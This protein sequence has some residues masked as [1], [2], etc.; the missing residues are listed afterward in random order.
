M[1]GTRSNRDQVR[2]SRRA[3]LTPVS[4]T[5]SRL[6]LAGHLVPATE[7]L[8]R[9]EALGRL[10]DQGREVALLVLHQAC[11][12]EVEAGEVAAE[13]EQRNGSGRDQDGEWPVETEQQED[14]G[15]VSADVDDQEDQPERHEPSDGA[16]VAGGSGQQLP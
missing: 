3:L 14:D 8:D 16:Q 9:P 1:L 10:L 6:E 7:C 15:H 12:S 11:G 13:V 4:W 2:A 5:S